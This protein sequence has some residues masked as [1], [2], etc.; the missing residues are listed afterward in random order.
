MRIFKFTIQFIN[1]FREENF[2]IIWCK[3]WKLSE[4]KNLEMQFNK[5]KNVVLNLEMDLIFGGRDHAGPYFE[6]G[7]L[8]WSFM[9]SL[10]DNR[11][12]DDETDTWE[13]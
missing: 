6:I 13:Q 12:W 7:L 10:P 3:N 9:L 8:G 1:C 4:N 2:E 11:H 5:D